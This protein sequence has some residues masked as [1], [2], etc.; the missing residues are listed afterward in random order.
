MHDTGSTHETDTTLKASPAVLVT[1]GGTGIGAAV[2]D[3]MAAAGWQVAICGRRQS[4]LEEVS[5]A[6]GAHAISADLSEPMAPRR[7]VEE[8]VGLLGRLDG[9]VLNA[10][11]VRPGGIADLADHDWDAMLATNLTA[12][13]RLLQAALPHVLESQ[14][15]VV[16][17]ASMS[18]LRATAGIAGYNASKAGLNMLLKSAAVDYGPQGLR[19][20]VVCPG[21]TKTEMADT[22]MAQLG[23]E[24]GLDVEQAYELATAMVPLRRPASASEVAAV[25]AWLLSPQASYV[26]GVSLPVDGGQAP[27][28]VGTIAFDPRLG[29]T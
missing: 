8:T 25:I 2:A 19:A 16:G 4:A 17:V 23:D 26:N 18:A 5:R 28:D 22:E 10:G 1:G 15:S 12:P 14:G 27:V 24:R 11:I 6:T 20:N 21:W 9:L 3:V 29:M 13:F 7:V